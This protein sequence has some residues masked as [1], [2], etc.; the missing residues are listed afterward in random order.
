MAFKLI[1]NIKSKLAENNNINNFPGADSGLSYD[2]IT[3]NLRE[4]H[5]NCINPILEEFPDIYIASAYRCK[6]LNKF[7]G[8][9]ENSQH[10]YGYA[11]DIVHPN[12]PSSL[13]WNWCFQNLPTWNQLIWEFPERG[14]S[15]GGANIKCSWV[16][17]S[18]IVGDN[19]RKTSLSSN[20]EDL[21]EMYAGE[22]QTR[23]GKYTHTINFADENYL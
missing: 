8:G 13:I 23:K 18:Y 16:H 22:L 14:D 11:A 7:L 20:R 6:E 5:L 2:F 15:S 1:H 4:L 19:T 17:I 3:N 9:T 12:F 10:V 21:H